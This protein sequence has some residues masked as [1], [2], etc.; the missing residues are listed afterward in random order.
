MV[1]HQRKVLVVGLPQ[2]G[3]TTFLAALWDI[4]GS[5][6][7]AGS[8]KLEK[9]GGD[10][11]HLNDIRDLWADCNKVARTRTANERVVSMSLRDVRT[12]TTS[13]VVFSD[14]SGESFERQWTERA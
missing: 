11:Q 9:L 8:L 2:T 12:N 13:E 14:M 3:K 6:E 5:G 1:V 10:Q 7:V 4:V